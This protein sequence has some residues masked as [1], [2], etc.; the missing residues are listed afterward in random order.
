M[1]QLAEEKKSGT[2]EL[3]LTKAV[4]NRQVVLGKFLACLLLVIIALLFTLPYY[5]TVSQL[6]NIDHGATICGY[7]SLLLMSAAYISIGLFT[8]SITNNQI[9][10]FL[11]ALFIG[12]FFHFLFDVM[13]GGSTGFMAQLFDTLS[14]NTHYDSITRGIIDSKDLI[15][16]LSIM[17]PFNATSVHNAAFPIF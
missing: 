3:L 1:R 12:I 5:Y 16:F 8:S 4:S 13:S 17:V 15:Y 7:F 9:V 2:I 6:G 14:M 10:A 11:L